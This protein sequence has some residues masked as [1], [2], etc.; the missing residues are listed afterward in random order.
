[1]RMDNHVTVGQGQVGKNKHAE[2]QIQRNKYK[3][4]HPVKSVV[5]AQML[6]CD[7]ELPAHM[8]AVL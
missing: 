2:Y 4:H 5:N 8:M 3:K 6:N 7:H 1:M